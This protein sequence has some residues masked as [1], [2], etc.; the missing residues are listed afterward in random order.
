[1][2]TRAKD[3]AMLR[4]PIQIFRTR[5]RAQKIGF[6]GEKKINEFSIFVANSK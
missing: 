1:M 6:S 2:K 5:S 3:C 4:T